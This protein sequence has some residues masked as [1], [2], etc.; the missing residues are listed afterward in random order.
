MFQTLNGRLW[1]MWEDIS[2]FSSFLHLLI[3]SFPFFPT[4]FAGYNTV[5]ITKLLW[6]LS[7]YAFKKYFLK[8]QRQSTATLE[9][10]RSEWRT[11]TLCPSLCFLNTNGEQEHHGWKNQGFVRDPKHVLRILRITSTATIIWNK[12]WNIILWF[13]SF[14]A[15]KLLMAWSRWHSNL[16]EAKQVW[17]M[18]RWNKTMYAAWRKDRIYRKCYE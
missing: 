6:A 18:P 13:C 1:V 2:S 10:Q 7:A 11:N 8:E 15:V 3:S 14:M 4:T 17:W 12:Y 16:A 9:N 5:I